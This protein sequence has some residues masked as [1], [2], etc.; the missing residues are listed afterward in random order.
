MYIN[1]WNYNVLAFFFRI[2]FL[3]N[4]Q[5]STWSDWWT[6][7]TWTS[8]IFLFSPA[9]PLQTASGRFP[10]HKFQHVFFG[11]QG[12]PVRVP[13]PL[14]AIPHFS[15]RFTLVTSVLQSPEWIKRNPNPLEALEATG[16]TGVI[17]LH[18]W[19]INMEPENDG[20]EDHVPLQLG[21]F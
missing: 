11:W 5:T 21:D 17:T 2:S 12:P 18:P 4:K 10:P 19:K 7:W 15:S 20:L 16:T 13:A 14:A 8:L 1:I 3:W 9:P 6:I